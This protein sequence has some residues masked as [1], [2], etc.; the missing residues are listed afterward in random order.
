MVAN[1]ACM[2]ARGSQAPLT[3]TGGPSANPVNQDIPVRHSIVW[4]NPVRSRHGPSRPKAGIRTMMSSPLS[5]W[6]RSQ[7]KPNCSMTRGVK[8]STR[9]S[10]VLSKR[11]SISA[12]SGRERSKVTPRFPMFA[13]WKIGLHSHQRSSDDG[14]VLAKRMLSGRVSDSTLMTSA[15]SAARAAVVTGP[16]HQAV[17]STMRTPSRGSRQPSS[18]TPRAVSVLAPLAVPGRGAQ[19]I[20]PSC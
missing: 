5:A 3:R 19:S 12:P 9:M 11:S 1:A 10:A 18:S 17:Q 4:A 20:D 16:A 15:P 6:T 13:A 14:R 2:P 8:F 7:S